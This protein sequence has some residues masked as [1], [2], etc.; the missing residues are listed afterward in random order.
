[1]LPPT[2]QFKIDAGWPDA[3]IAG[4]IFGLPNQLDTNSNPPK[5]LLALHGWLDNS[6]SFRPIAAHLTA[7]KEYYIIAIDF[8]GMGLSSKLP[9][10]VPYS[11]QMQVM[12]VRRV[13]THFGLKQYGL[14]TH[15]FGATV[16]LAVIYSSLN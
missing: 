15:S 3:H 7:L 14:L 6:N 9:H 4:Q 8:F 12:C 11:I 2:S 13:V 16:G 10:G 5:P 1:M